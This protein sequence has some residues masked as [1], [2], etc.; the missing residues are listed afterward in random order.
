MMSELRWIELGNDAA[1]LASEE[2]T[3]EEIAAMREYIE[4]RRRERA[5]DLHRDTALQ[6][7]HDEARMDRYLDP[8]DDDPVDL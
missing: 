2:L 1:V 8:P 4:W 3:P 5:A 7:V 6:R